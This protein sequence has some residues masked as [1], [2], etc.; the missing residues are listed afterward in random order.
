MGVK[1][2]LAGSYRETVLVIKEEVE[3]VEDFGGEAQ[4]R[5][6]VFG[7]RVPHGWG[8]RFEVEGVE[9]GVSGFTREKLVFTGTEVTTRWV[10]EVEEV[11]MLDEGTREVGEEAVWVEEKGWDVVGGKSVLIVV[12]GMLMEM[13]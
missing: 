12:R 3:S 2:F 5:H 4:E 10:G 6:L 11:I 8:I 9:V 13:R 7:T 1:I